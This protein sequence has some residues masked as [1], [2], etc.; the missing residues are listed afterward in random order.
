MDNPNLPA[1][2]AKALSLPLEPGVYI[3]KD[4]GGKII[5]I[6]KAK[7]LKN[8]VSSYFRSVEKHTPK[9]YQMVQNVRDFEYI[10]AGTEFEALILEC[11]LIKQHRHHY[12]ILLK[13][14]KEI[15][16]AHV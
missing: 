1:L 3:M 2:R 13:D 5:Y 12:N 15:G 7:V 14:D 4:S 9:V 11:S 10:V 6:G 8:R 16:R